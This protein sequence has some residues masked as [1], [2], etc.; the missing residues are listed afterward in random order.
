[1]SHARILVCGV[2]LAIGLMLGVPSA[3]AQGQQNELVA[4][5]QQIKQLTEQGRF[6]EAIAPAKRLLAQ[7]ERMVGKSHPLY[8]AQLQML[9][10]AHQLNGD[11]A[12]AESLYKQALALRERNLGQNHA[13]T[14]ASLAVLASLYVNAARLDEAE[15]LLQRA[16]RIREAALRPNDPELGNTYA[17]LGN[18]A[19][20]RSDLAGARRQYERALAMLD[21][22]GLGDHAYYP[23][24]LNNLAEVSKS[25]GRYADAERLLKQ[26]L[27]I[28]ARKFGETSPFIAPNL[29]NLGDLYRIMG[30]YDESEALHRRELALVETQGPEHPSV[31]TSLNNLALLLNARGRPQE[32]AAL[33]ERALR[34]Q[35]RRLG[36]NHPAVATALNNLAEIRRSLDKNAEA[37][38]LLRRSLAIRIAAAGETSPSAAVALDNLATV[39]LAQNRGTDA[40]VLARRALAIRE[41]VLPAEHVQI[42]TSLSNLGLILD[43]Q[44]RTADALPLHRRALAIRQKQYGAG[45]PDTAIGLN[46]LAAN[47]LDAGAWQEAYAAFKQ[48]NDILVVR[49][50]AV[51]A[52][53]PSASGG[54]ARDVEINRYGGSFLGLMRAAYALQESADP[55][56]RRALSDEAFAA[57]QRASLSSAADA[58]TRMSA[59]LAAG[60]GPAADLMR[61]QQD[62]TGQQVA[63][64]KALLGSLSQTGSARKPEAEAELRRRAQGL[65]AELAQ[66][67]GQIA[68]R[69]PRLAELADPKPLGIAQVRQLLRPDEAFYAVA[70]TR[71]GAFAWVI[72]PTEE[73]WIRID[74]TRDALAD[75][76]AALRCGLDAAADQARC[77]RLQVP[78]TPADGLPAF[79]LAR[80][81]ALYKVL[82]GEV[83]DL[84]KGRRL[85]VVPAGPLTQL[86]LHVLVTHPPQP[87]AASAQAYREAAWL[88]RDTAITVLPSVAS[89]EALRRHAGQSA[90]SRTYLGI[91]NPLLTGPDQRFTAAA[92]AARGK[93]QCAAP[94]QV[95]SAAAVRGGRTAQTSRGIRAMTVASALADPSL[96]ARQVPLPETADELCAVAQHLEAGGGNVRLG[97]EASETVVKAASADGSLANHRILHFATHGAV[98][99]EITGLVEPGLLLTPPRQATA[100]DDGYLSAAEIAELKVD[101]DLVILSACNTA[102]GGADDAAAL[103]GLARAFFY[104]G[105]RGLLV[106][107][108]AVFSDS[109]VKLITGALSAR[110][111]D[112]RM[113]W[114]QALQAS[115]VNL[116]D[117]GTPEEAH[118]SYWAP[119]VLVGGAS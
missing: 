35:E 16:I 118:P 42:A 1:M 55:A 115:M 109:T 89:L 9:G 97:G 58:I 74:R 104:A 78:E 39:L 18:I 59:R 30:R 54:S 14:A 108:W 107:H 24:V 113:P 67:S 2:L 96:I 61:R 32:A 86:P 12:E 114:P 77:R 102:A 117:R 8:A 56:A 44:G 52:A 63:I 23:V 47:R 116:I 33:M 103:S 27:T 48:S 83:E 53:T 38:A 37:E 57:M 111:A 87:G 72:T 81:H 79:D 4:L 76:V 26:A 65:S 68:E 17:V 7:V 98:S 99:G 69:V 5:M 80:A 64:D 6:G 25:E 105:A 51:L 100:R 20:Q 3:Q 10:Q 36:A 82:F 40:E 106:S 95:A 41:R 70:L 85:L 60:T 45:H 50:A 62:L 49:R 28:N 75:D 43:E 46:N 112:A 71:G 93:R 110:T 31:A 90:A 119:F 15:A 91:G 92:E 73:R 11:T 21:R 101:A 88:A 19:Y 94:T 34:I 22:N 13:D 66:V 29:N 84:I